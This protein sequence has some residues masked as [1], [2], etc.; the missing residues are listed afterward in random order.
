MKNK[1]KNSAWFRS[2]FKF[3]VM[4]ILS[5]LSLSGCQ[6]LTKAFDEHIASQ[7]T[8]QQQTIESTDWAILP[9]V[10]HVEVPK[11]T[12]VQLERILLVQL[13]DAGITNLSIYQKTQSRNSVPSYVAD[14]YELER[15]R[16]WAMTKQ[17]RYTLSGE[18]MGWQYDDENRFS[19]LLNLK[20][21]DITTGEEV[22]SLEGL[23]EGRPG[24]EPFAVSRKLLI[25]LLAALPI[26]QP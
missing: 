10:S 17:V 4:G 20:V 14:V 19:T 2:Q 7:L 21:M 8:G 1:R 16:L 3:A 26:D 5:L 15:A 24:E 9:F 12:S 18:I 22:W 23:G 25:D 13:P 11:N 6:S